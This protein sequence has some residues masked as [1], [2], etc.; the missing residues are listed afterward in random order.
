MAPNRWVVEDNPYT[1]EFARYTAGLAARNRHYAKYQEE[2]V[3]AGC[4]GAS[5]CT[6]GFAQ[7][8]DGAPCSIPSIS[9]NGRMSKQKVRDT[10]IYICIDKY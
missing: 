1:R 2:M 3:K 10:Y 6:H 4:M 5:H 8:Y 9:V 7:V